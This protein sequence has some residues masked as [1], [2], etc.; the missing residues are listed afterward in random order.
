[1]VLTFLP[2][3]DNICNERTIRLRVGPRRARKSEGLSA[4]SS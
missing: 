4:A 1:P 2:P 3:T